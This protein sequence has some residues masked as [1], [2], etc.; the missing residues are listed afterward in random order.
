MTHLPERA[1]TLTPD[2]SRFSV[3]LL[4][5][6]S[7]VERPLLLVTHYRLAVPQLSAKFDQLG[8]SPTRHTWT[9][10]TLPFDH[11]TTLT[12]GTYTYMSKPIGRK[13]RSGLGP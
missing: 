12:C 3:L 10:M 13:T 11:G 5:Y 6:S 8:I 1:H 9:C 2:S 7:D 4:L